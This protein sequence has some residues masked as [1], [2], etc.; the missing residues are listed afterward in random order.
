MLNKIAKELRQLSIETTGET[1]RNFNDVI[2]NCHLELSGAL[3]EYRSGRNNEWHECNRKTAGEKI[4]IC[5]PNAI[6]CPK[7]DPNNCSYCDISPRG[8]G[9]KLADCMIRILEYCATENID[10]QGILDR[11]ISYIKNIIENNK[12]NTI[13]EV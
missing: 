7:Y 9:V 12:E 2:A 1:E 3:L 8:I 4:K 11:R 13:D 5:S 10:I 6:G